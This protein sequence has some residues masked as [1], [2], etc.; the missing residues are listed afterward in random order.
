M[1][2]VIGGYTFFCRLPEEKYRFLGVTESNGGI[3][4]ITLSLPENFSLMAR[5]FRALAALN[6]NKVKGKIVPLLI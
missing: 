2:F 5:N 4:Y 6:Y 3:C 1:F